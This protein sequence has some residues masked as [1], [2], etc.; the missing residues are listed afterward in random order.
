M[1]GT[2]YTQSMHSDST[3]LNEGMYLEVTKCAPKMK[4]FSQT[5]LLWNYMSVAIGV[6]NM[7]HCDFWTKVYNNFGLLVSL[8]YHVQ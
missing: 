1:Q 7:R 3:Q 6:Q 8:S 5:M 4:T 2:T